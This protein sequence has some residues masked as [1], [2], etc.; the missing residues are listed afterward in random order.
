MLTKH[1][2]GAAAFAELAAEWDELASQGITDT[3]FQTCAYQEAWWQHLQPPEAD[4]HTVTARTE[5]GRLAAIGCFYIVE[6]VLHFNGCVEETDYLDLIVRAEEAEAGWTAVFQQLL[7]PDFPHWHTARLCNIPA[8][9]PTRRLL[10]QLAQANGLDCQEELAE[11]CP[12]I[13]LPATFD[14][15][16]DLLDSKQRREVQRKLRRAAGADAQLIIVGPDDDLPQAV[17]DFLAL[18]QRS[19]FEKRDWLTDGRRAVF[20]QV[21]QSA[22]AAGTL[23]LMFI[24]VNNQK[25]A[26]LFNF[27]YRDRIW[28]YNS[29]LDPEAFGA[30]SLGVVLTAKAI[31]HAIENGRADFDF[32]RGNE[33]YKYRFGAQDTEI[34]RLTLT[35]PADNPQ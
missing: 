23:Q 24:E 5:D 7:Q 13:A 34:F 8:T 32:L 12:I 10:P 21:A 22:M 2:N 20:H 26:A 3:P 15:Y 33:T 16:L 19:T 4:L 28:V 9:S 14:A 11:V 27:D 17:D 6:G 18:L 30:L 1:L 31:E 25:A 35:R 29:G